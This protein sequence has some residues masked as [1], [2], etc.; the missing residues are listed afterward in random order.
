MHARCFAETQNE[1]TAV[2]LIRMLLF[3][4]SLMGSFACLC[5]CL[6]FNT[7]VS[8]ALVFNWSF[9][10]ALAES[11][12]HGTHGGTWRKIEALGGN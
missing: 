1:Q 5:A 6:C 9:S 8:D 7:A 3:H 12:G 2:G 10:V 11:R 4:L